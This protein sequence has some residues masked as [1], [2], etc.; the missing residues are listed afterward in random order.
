MSS[1]WNHNYIKT[2]NINM[3]Y[4]TQGEGQLMVLLHGF[5]EFWYSWRFQIKELGKYFK[6]VAPDL[7]GYNKTD[8][9]EGV[10]NY[11]INILINDILGLV[12]GLG[13]EK[14]IIVGHDW[15]G[16]ISWEYAKCFP[17]NT[18]KLII[19]N[20]PP[21]NVLQKAMGTNK[22]QAR[23]SQYIVFFQQP[24]APEQM[25]SASN[26]AG[27]KST[28]KSMAVKKELWDKET[29]DKFVEALKLPTL[30]C[31]I[32]YYR[33]SFQFPMRAKQRKL[34]V[35][36]PTLVI[37]GEQDNAL[38]KEL[39]YHFPEIVEGPYTIKYIPT[40]GHWVQQE[41]PE[42]VNKYLL[43]FLGV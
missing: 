18:E 42:L 24:E 12:K 30:S 14:A 26:Y 36:C 11:K 6:V 4:V 25:L 20:C 29:L 8:K 10:E 23:R 7:R 2:N 9:P 1:E 43:E 16:A 21:I 19:L 3:H 34:K 41:E 40:A 28:Y 31:G 13:E 38:G 33:A 39:T 5:P 15:G 32:N 37:W 22:E 27:L 17:D 35:K